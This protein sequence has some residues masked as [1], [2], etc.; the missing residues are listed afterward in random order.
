[1]Y[2]PVRL[3]LTLDRGLQT[4]HTHWYLHWP[5]DYKPTISVGV[6]MGSWITNPLHKMRLVTT[7]NAL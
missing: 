2:G 4:Y 6:Y 5:V 1:M 7:S 3:G